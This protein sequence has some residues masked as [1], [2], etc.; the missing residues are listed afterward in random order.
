[1]LNIYTQCQEAVANGILDLTEEEFAFLCTCED[2]EL[3]PSYWEERLSEAI[4]SGT[5]YEGLMSSSTIL[6]SDEQKLAE[7]DAFADNE[8]TGDATLQVSITVENRWA[9]AQRKREEDQIVPPDTARENVWEFFVTLDTPERLKEAARKATA[10]M[11]VEKI[12]EEVMK[13]FLR[14]I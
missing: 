14:M 13:K 5:D 7:L 8:D 1:M 4:E 12:T 2:E 11:A 10:Y 6:E 3:Y 9:K